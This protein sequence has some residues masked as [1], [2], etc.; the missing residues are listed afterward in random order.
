MTETFLE[1]YFRAIAARSKFLAHTNTLPSFFA[2]KSK[3]DLNEFDNAVRNVKKNACLLLETGP[4]ELEINDNPRD[5][6]RIGLHVLL[7]TTD[8]FE[9]IKAARDKAKY[10]LIS[11]ISAMRRDMEGFGEYS[12]NSA[13]PLAQAGVILQNVGK[14]DDM[15]GVEGNWY[16]KVIYFDFRTPVSQKYNPADWLS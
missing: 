14:Y 5:N 3:V 2:V 7:K 13:G 11:I 16:G 12:N 9:D 4:G 15:D 1:D 6:C 8:K 10:V